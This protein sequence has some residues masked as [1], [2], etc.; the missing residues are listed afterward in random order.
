MF[1][2][3]TKSKNTEGLIL[4]STSSC[5][6][7]PCCK[8]QQLTDVLL[9]YLSNLLFLNLSI[10]DVSNILHIDFLLLKTFCSLPMVVL[11]YQFLGQSIKGSHY[12]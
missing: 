1:T 9:V 11:C 8:R 5:P 6:N 2:V 7:S 12:V 3:K 10:L 4:K